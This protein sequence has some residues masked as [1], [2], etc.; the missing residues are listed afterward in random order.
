MGKHRN[1]KQTKVPQT[2]HNK[3]GGM[4]QA[5]TAGTNAKNN[6]R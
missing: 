1:V 5:P 4:P 6:Y 2:Q 3:A